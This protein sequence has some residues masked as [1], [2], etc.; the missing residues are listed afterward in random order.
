MPEIQSVY[1]GHSSYLVATVWAAI[2]S[3]LPICHVKRHRALRMRLDGCIGTYQTLDGSQIPFC[4]N[5]HPATGKLPG[6]QGWQ[7]E[8]MSPFEC[9]HRGRREVMP[10]ALQAE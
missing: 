3:L 8:I 4:G 5:H 9:P 10:P 1:S 2:Y 7:S 6:E